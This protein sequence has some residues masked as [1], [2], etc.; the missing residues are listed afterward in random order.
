MA[1]IPGFSTGREAAQ[2][3]WGRGNLCGVCA[4]AA[5]LCPTGTELCPCSWRE[6]NRW[7]C[8]HSRARHGSNE[9]CAGSRSMIA[10]SSG[11][12]CPFLQSLSIEPLE[13]L[14]SFWPNRVRTVHRDWSFCMVSLCGPRKQSRWDV[15]MTWPPDIW[16]AARLGQMECTGHFQN[17]LALPPISSNYNP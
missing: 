3:F 15:T 17:H 5:I 4:A 1:S 13:P 9:T 14:S 10:D 12:G 2:S 11:L 7:R 16:S 8:I 6:H